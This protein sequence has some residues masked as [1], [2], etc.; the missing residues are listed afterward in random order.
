MISKLSLLI[1]VI[2]LLNYVLFTSLPLRKVVHSLYGLV[3]I[4]LQIQARGEWGE[5]HQNTPLSNLL[6]RNPTLHDGLC[7]RRELLLLSSSLPHPSPLA[8]QACR[9]RLLGSGGPRCCSPGGP[10]PCH[11]WGQ[12]SWCYAGPWGEGGHTG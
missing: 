7:Y 1:S 6:H 9:G 12:G 3:E 10:P 2:F 4:V 5:G 8:Q 11:R